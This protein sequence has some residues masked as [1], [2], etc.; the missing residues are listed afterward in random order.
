MRLCSL[1]QTTC[2]PLLTTTTPS[3]STHFCMARAQS[4]RLPTAT[5]SPNSASDARYQRPLRKEHEHG[6]L[7]EVASLSPP[8]AHLIQPSRVPVA[9]LLLQ[10]SERFKAGSPEGTLADASRDG[11]SDATDIIAPPAT[12]KR[13]RRSVVDPPPPDPAALV[14]MEAALFLHPRLAL[15]ASCVCGR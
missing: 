12:R 14:R 9:H 8:G 11:V 6:K 2:S 13:I 10:F 4:F 5:T 7:Q 15:T 1:M 3:S